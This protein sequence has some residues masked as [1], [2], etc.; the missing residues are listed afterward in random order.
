MKDDIYCSPS[1][2]LDDS[3]IITYFL[4]TRAMQTANCCCQTGKSSIIKTTKIKMKRENIPENL[5]FNE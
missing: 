5:N 4:F 3:F 2:V 1:Y